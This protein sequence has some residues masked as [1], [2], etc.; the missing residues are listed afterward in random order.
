LALWLVALLLLAGS[1][2]SPAGRPGG[3]VAPALALY[4]VLVLLVQ[5]SLRGDGN[6]AAAVRASAFWFVP[7]VAGGV[8]LPRAGRWWEATSCWCLVLALTAG[9]AFMVWHRNASVGFFEV[10]L[11]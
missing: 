9:A 7:G 3:W 5:P 1:V 4:A 11:D 6:A 2:L 8:M 10:I